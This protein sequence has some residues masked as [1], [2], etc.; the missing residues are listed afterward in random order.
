MCR[1]DGH[2]VGSREVR[3]LN[4]DGT[5]TIT[6]R[7]QMAKDAMEGTGGGVLQPGPERVSDADRNFG[8]ATI[9]NPRCAAD[10]QGSDPGGDRWSGRLRRSPTTSALGAPLQTAF[11]TVIRSEERA[12]LHFGRRALRG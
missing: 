5:I 8:T 7:L 9:V 12:V 3:Q 10:K 6:T 2:R 1:F 4:P 11:G